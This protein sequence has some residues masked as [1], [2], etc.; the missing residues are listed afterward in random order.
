[1][2]ITQP[3]KSGSPRLA[4]LL[5]FGFNYL[6]YPA[7]TTSSSLMG[8]PHSGITHAQSGQLAGWPGGGEPGPLIITPSL[9][10]NTPVVPVCALA[11]VAVQLLSCHV[12]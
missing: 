4:C 12:S 1:M 9:C 7:L 3:H 10:P 11:C 2:C 5:W 6:S 8:L